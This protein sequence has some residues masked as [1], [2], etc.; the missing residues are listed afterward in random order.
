[1]KHIVYQVLTRLWGKF[2]DWGEPAFQWLKALGVDYIWFAGIPRHASEEDFVKGHPGSPYAVSDWYDTNPYLADDPS[3]RMD[4]FKSLVKR[5]HAAGFKVIT[6]FIPN[7]VAKNYKGD[8]PTYNF[9]D[10]DWTD[11]LKVDYSNAATVPAMMEVLR[12]WADA[13]VDGFRCDMVEL[14]PVQ[15]LQD[16]ISAIKGEYPELIFIGEVYNRN[17]YRTFLDN[18]G[19]NLLY[20]KSGMYDIVRGL[21]AGER[22]TREITWNW[23]F[24]GDS[25]DRMLN[26]LENHDEQRCASR[27]FAGS[28]E[29]SIPA[30]AV[31]LLFNTAWYM[32][33][34]GEELGEDASESIDGRTSIF[35]WSRVKTIDCLKKNFSISPHPSIKSLLDLAKLPVFKNGEVYDLCWCNLESTGFNADKHFA[36]LR[37]DAQ[38]CRLVFCNFS[39]APAMA[40]I[41]IPEE[42]RQRCG[43]SSVLVDCKPWDATWY[44][45]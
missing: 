43:C 38:E 4:E 8:I 35:N 36:F 23:Q 18:A 31:S 22:S 33:Y 16:I 2:G 6:D 13:G 45:I 30:M 21:T 24:L 12:F 7:H 29:R 11:T 17:N 32:I 1:M 41:T 27:F 40:E 5:C 42:M 34:F 15:A 25:Q 14:V 26:F 19:F 39:D 20:D 28:V 3:H 37:Y 9:C 44:S 10:G